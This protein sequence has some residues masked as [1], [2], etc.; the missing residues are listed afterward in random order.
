M[1]VMCV[2]R[3]GYVG[4]IECTE[5]ESVYDYVGRNDILYITEDSTIEESV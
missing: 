4:S 3:M 1:C 2:M 5:C